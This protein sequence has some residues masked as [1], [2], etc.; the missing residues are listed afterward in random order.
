MN[1]IEFLVYRVL[2][3]LGLRRKEIFAGND[4][5]D[6]LGMDSLEVLYLVNQLEIKLKISIPDADLEKL[7]SRESTV[8]YL[9]ER[10]SLAS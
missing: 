2:R 6:E 5:K 7:T 3:K 1:N 8:R 9:S 4:F 10:A